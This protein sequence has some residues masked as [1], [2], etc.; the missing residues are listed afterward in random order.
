MKTNLLILFLCSY[1][2]TV[3]Q[4]NLEYS[5]IDGNVNR[6]KLENSG[7]KYYLLDNVTKQVK[8]YNANHSLWK[9][10]NLVAD[11]NP[12]ELEISH[13]SETAINADNFIEICYTYYTEINSEI[14]YTSKI[15]NENSTVLL[16]VANASSIEV[17]QIDG[18]SNKIIALI[19]DGNLSSKVYSI[20][21]LN[22]ENTYSNGYIYRVKLENSGEKYYQL[23]ELSAH[24][25][26][27]NANHTSWKSIPIFPINN[28]ISI[29]LNHVSETTL[30]SD[31]KVE[32][33][34]SSYNSSLEFEGKISNEDGITLATFPGVQSFQVNK[35]EG[36]T[37]KLI[38]IL[39][40]A[41]F[42][43]SSKVFNIATLTAEQTY[44]DGVISRIKLENSGEKYYLLNQTSNE[45]KLY[46]ANHTFWKSIN[47]TT[48]PNATFYGLSHISEK[49]INDDNLIE[50]VYS[51]FVD[52]AGVINYESRIINENN[53]QLFAVENA[54]W[55]N[56]NILN[57]FPNKL[58]AYMDGL[59]QNSKVY[60]LPAT[61]LTVK[62]D[63]LEISEFAIFPNP[64][65]EIINVEVKNSTIKH[66]V[67]TTIIGKIV[68]EIK[69]TFDRLTLDI[70][71]LNAGVYFVVGQTTDGN[72]IREKIIIY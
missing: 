17:S 59:N 41:T 51:F 68:K 5:Y 38:G 43:S 22:L 67:L 69:L 40:D 34:Y 30:N 21:S 8:I 57:G 12:L 27:F 56:V 19:D 20:P 39:I 61:T 16:S 24:I 31:T 65:H 15:I 7:E 62:D 44:V 11:P 42:N 49:N 63:L 53:S 58:I 54:T 48:L 32:V 36:L 14:T 70:S 18:L 64:A 28:S 4:I 55:F 60:G 45:L 71:D 2:V 23:S 47:L 52:N 46:N 6:I 10:I 50:V 66:L 25:N 37:T 35:I 1:W 26:L 13:I 33:I 29:N 72:M 3:G 9:T